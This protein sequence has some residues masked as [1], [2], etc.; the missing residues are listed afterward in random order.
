MVRPIG[1]RPMTAKERAKR[2]RD[3]KKADAAQHEAYLVSER[4]RWAA[5]RSEN[6]TPRIEQMTRRQHKA[7]KKKWRES[8]R[9]TKIKNA[10]VENMV[11][12]PQSPVNNGN[13]V[14]ENGNDMNNNNPDGRAVEG[15]KRVHRNRSKTSRRLIKALDELEK[16]RKLIQCY[17]VRLHRQKKKME[18][19]DLPQT[20]RKKV[21]TLL[22]DSGLNNQVKQRMIRQEALMQDLKYSMKNGKVKGRQIIRIATAKKYNKIG[23]ASCRER[24]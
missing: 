2:W 16:N 1:D 6:K 13:A 10:A 5:R 24:V 17:K 15:R 7:V 12:P 4:A 8:K 3:K 21:A 11:T 20:P 14:A 19:K 18:A 23:R 22:R 9:A